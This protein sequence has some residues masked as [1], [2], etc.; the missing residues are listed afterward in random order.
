MAKPNHSIT[1]NISSRFPVFIEADCDSFGAIFASMDDEEQ[2]HVLRSMVEHMQPHA[3]QWD[4]ISI[5]L[6]KPEN[7]ALRDTLRE[8]L[9]PA[10]DGGSN[11]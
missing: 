8:V 10:L 4:Y 7:K 11:G 6:E 5:A 1:V 9:F 3:M 2:I